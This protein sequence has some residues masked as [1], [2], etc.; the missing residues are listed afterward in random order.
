MMLRLSDGRRGERIVEDCNR[1]EEIDAV[2]LEVASR[3]R[4]VELEAQALRRHG[5]ILADAGE[6]GGGAGGESAKDFGFEALQAGRFSLERP[7][8]F[9]IALEHD[10]VIEIR[11]K[12]P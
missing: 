11:A 12:M 3:L 4:G 1:F 2:L 6:G 8:H 10:V 9:A 5:G 7:M